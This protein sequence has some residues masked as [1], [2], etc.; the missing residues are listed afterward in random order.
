MGM[1]SVISGTDRRRE[2]DAQPPRVVVAGGGLAGLAIALSLGRAGVPVTLFESAPPPP[3]GPAPEVAPHWHRGTVPQANHPHMLTSAGVKILRQRAPEVLADAVEAGAEYI[4]IAAALPALLEPRSQPG[5]EELVALACRRTVLE[6]LLR[7][8]IEAMDG[9]RVVDSC[10]VVGIVVDPERDRVTAADTEHGTR[11]PADIVIDAT[12]RR[13]EARRWLT[14]GS[15][16]LRD[17][18]QFADSGCRGVGRFYRLLRPGYPTALHRGNAAGAIGETFAAVVHPADNDTF[19]VTLATLPDDELVHELADDDGFASV[20]ASIP[21]IAPWVDRLTSVPITAAQEY[22][23]APNTLRA[24][25]VTRQMPVAG[26]YPVGDAACLTNPL[27]GRGMSLAFQHAFALA[28]VLVSHPAVDRVQ[29]DR[30][31]ACARDL[32]VVWFRQAAADDAARIRLWRQRLDGLATPTG[33]RLPP[34]RPSLAEIG[35]AAAGDSFVWRRLTRVLMGLQTPTDAF[36]DAPFKA[37]MRAVAAPRRVPLLPTRETISRVLA[38][39][40]ID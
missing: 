38:G 31:A 19:S 15:Y 14:S 37:R 36:G 11:E 26:L 2:I 5:D 8:R 1:V 24:A 23:C 30:A 21:L 40:R 9:V 25:A 34:D 28:D 35:A 16:L 32:F 20:V 7:R 12:G 4:D 39:A 18:D 6:L 17:Q 29:V 10:R 27:Y 33:R 3:R 13:A 22:R